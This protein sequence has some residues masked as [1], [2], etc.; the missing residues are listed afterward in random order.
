MRNKLKYGVTADE[1]LHPRLKDQL[2]SLRGAMVGAAET[3][4]LPRRFQTEAHPDRPAI[5]ITDAATG[6]QAS[7]SLYAYGATRQVLNELFG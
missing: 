2:Q 1:R 7:V 6:R 3:F 4:P 5:I